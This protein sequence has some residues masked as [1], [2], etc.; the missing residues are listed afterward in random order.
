MRFVSSELDHDLTGDDTTAAD[1]YVADS[2]ACA[3]NHRRLTVAGEISGV[4]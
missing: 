1:I 2:R 4:R 3:Q